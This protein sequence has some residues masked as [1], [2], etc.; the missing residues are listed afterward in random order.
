MSSSLEDTLLA[1]GEAVKSLRKSAG[2]SQQQVA[3]RGKIHLTHVS[4][5]ERGRINF[6]CSTMERIA[7]GLGVSP[8]EIFSL[9]GV[10]ARRAER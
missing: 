4:R 2:L 6:T 3:D 9:A 7:E 8:A 5:V 10:F 1:V